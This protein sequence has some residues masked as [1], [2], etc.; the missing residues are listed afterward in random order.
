MFPLVHLHL[1]IGHKY[2]H[3]P[4]FSHE[5]V[6][7]CLETRLSYYRPTLG[8]AFVAQNMASKM[9]ISDSNSDFFQL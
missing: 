2:I 8:S 3:N 7:E 6:E 5:C 4:Q 1:S 9:N